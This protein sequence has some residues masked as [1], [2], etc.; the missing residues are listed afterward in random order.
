MPYF[1]CHEQTQN[2]VDA[3]KK[4]FEDAEKKT[5]RPIKR[6]PAF[7]CD[8]IVCGKNVSNVSPRSRAAQSDSEVKTVG[9]NFDRLAIEKNDKIPKSHSENNIFVNKNK[10]DYSVKFIKRET[11]VLAARI[12]SYSIVNKPKKEL[13]PDLPETLK[14]ALKSPLPTGPPPKKPPRTFTHTP[15]H[16]AKVDAKL[17]L[18]KIESYILKH[19]KNA[20]VI[21]PR[22]SEEVKPL[23]QKDSEQCGLSN[24]NCLRECVDDDNNVY[25]KKTDVRSEDA[26]KKT[27]PIVLNFLNRTNKDTAKTAN[28]G[29]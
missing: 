1:P 7:R 2:R 15:F 6:S 8:R 5:D 16:E 27:S 20:H 23:V 11:D 9:R 18:G 24:L 29:K 3:I 17:K 25:T 14:L 22:K 28:S 13:S 26:G 4:K 21:V 10:P 19:D 12:P